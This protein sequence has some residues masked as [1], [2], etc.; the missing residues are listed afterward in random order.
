MSGYTMI[1]LDVE[2]AQ[3]EME[4]ILGTLAH[5][6]DGVPRAAMRAVNK[7]IVTLRAEAVRA[8]RDKYAAKA[9]DLRAGMSIRKASLT[10]LEALLTASGRKSLPLFAFS[11]RPAAPG[12]RPPKGASVQVLKASGRKVVPGAFV[13]RMRSG[14]LGLFKRDGSARLGIHELFGP[15]PLHVFQNEEVILK[16]DDLIEDTMARNLEREA[17][18]LLRQAGL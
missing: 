5:I 9:T 11:P 17:S 3:S 10:T 6:K 1:R 14:H 13:A 7:S 2:D 15:S 18:W 4:R 12:K 16:L 8:A